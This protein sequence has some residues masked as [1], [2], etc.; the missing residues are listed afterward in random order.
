MDASQ[1]AHTVYQQ[2]TGAS[3]LSGI[4][5]GNDDLHASAAEKT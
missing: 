4:N 1:Q 5:I 2:E 3:G